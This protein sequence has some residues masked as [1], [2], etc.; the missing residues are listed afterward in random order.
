MFRYFDFKV[1]G[2]FAD[3][4]GTLARDVYL[5][6]HRVDPVQLTFGQ[7]REPFSQEELR[8][9]SVQDF[10]ERS[11]VNNLAPSRS[12][13][14]MLSGVLKKGVIEYQ[15]GA[16]NGKGL[17]GLN[18]TGTPEGVV[19]LRF[20]PWKNS[21]DYWTKGLSFGGAYALGRNTGTSVRGLMESRSFIFFI[22]DTANGPVTHANG[23]LTWLIGPA[24]FRAE[25]DQVN[26]AR[27]GLGPGG[28]NLP[29]VVAKSYMGQFTY[30]LTGEDK[31]DSGP[32]VPK[33]NLFGGEAGGG[34]GAWELKLRYS[35]LQISDG[36]P[37]S[38]R[39]Q[40]I[41]FGANWYLNRFV[42]YV[43]DY[44]IEL[45]QDPLRTPRPGDRTFHVVLSRIQVAF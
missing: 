35:S 45:Y 41:Y 44:G 22:P 10:V 23:E 32:V 34:R 18:T 25:Y 12:P 37:K 19:R 42:R 24:T 3:T 5:R 40:S 6:V 1:E 28:N 20:S 9:D 39:G 13:G 36:T 8:L 26:Q 29:G 4:A 30:L 14:V 21:K 31:P 2:D 7:F 27:T 33:R 38:N 17:L 15:V 11:L 43:F 16:F